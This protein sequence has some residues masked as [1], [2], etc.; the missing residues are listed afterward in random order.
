MV[1][2][3]HATQALVTGG[4]RGG[5]GAAAAKALCEAGYRVTVTGTAHD[6]RAPDQ[7]G[8]L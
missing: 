7:F 8:Y 1:S 4:T 5:I 6:G 2:G 3:R